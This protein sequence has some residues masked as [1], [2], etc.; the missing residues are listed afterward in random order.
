MRRAMIFLA[1]LD[2]ALVVCLGVVLLH[3]HGAP[4]VLPA[5]ENGEAVSSAD[6]GKGANTEPADIWDTPGKLDWRLLSL[7]DLHRCVVN[8]RSVGCPEATIKD[9]ILAEVNRRYAP[10]ERALKLRY[11]DYELWESPSPGTR[12][13]LDSQ[14]QLMAL[15]NEKKA[16]LRD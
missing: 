8:L 15:Y 12:N 4:V 16:L 11:E 6:Y 1:F 14:M 7:A 13:V 3:W 5:V 2:A 9:I 10:R